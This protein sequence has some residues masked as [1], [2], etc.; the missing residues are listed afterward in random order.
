MPEN[1]LEMEL[2]RRIHECHESAARLRDHITTLTAQVEKWQGLAWRLA[3]EY[4]NPC[5]CTERQG[6]SL[7]TTLGEISDLY[8]Q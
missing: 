8:N 4:K 6:C 5:E 2:Q 7:C 1:T 3:T